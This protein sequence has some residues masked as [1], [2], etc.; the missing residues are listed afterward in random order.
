MVLMAL[1]HASYF[2]A[3]VHAVESWAWV[4]PFYAPQAGAGVLPIFLTR[5]ITHLCAPGF[6]LLMGAGMTWLHDSRKKNGWTSARIR[7]YFMTRGVVLLVVQHLVD[8]PAWL[9]GTLSAAAGMSPTPTPGGGS[10]YA[11]HFGV[12][13]ALGAAMIVWGALIE[14]PG[15]VVVAVSAAALV[16]GAVL[17]PA[18]AAHA[19]LFPIWKLLL[20]VPSHDNL[21]NVLYPFVPWLAPAGLGILTARFV[22]SRP[23]KTAMR[24]IIAGVLLLAVFTILRRPLSATRIRRWR[25]SSVSCRSRSILRAPP[26]S[27]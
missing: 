15:S 3:R 13:T 18:T 9:L 21:F 24:A 4:P 23:E 22:T 7:R 19:E 11:F 5:W 16:L 6:F 20:F 27:P 14:V 2:I 10:D 25:D 12:I 1:D 8:N 17:T 26:S